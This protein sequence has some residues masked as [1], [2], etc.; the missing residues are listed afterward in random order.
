[1]NALFLILAGLL[2][3]IAFLIILPPLWRKHPV[4]VADL[5]QRN[6][7]IARQRLDE[8]K[9]Q[10]KAGALTQAQYNGQLA[11]LEQALSD[12]LDITS[13]VTVSQSQGRWVVYLIV[14]AVP[15]VTGSLYFTLGNYQAVSHSAEMAAGNSAAPGPEEIIKMVSGLA[16]RLKSQPDN[17][18]GWLMLGRSYKYLQQYPEAVEAFANAYR[19]LGDQAEVMLLYADALAY[20][21]N[22]NLAGKPAELVF[23]ALAL[24]PENVNGLWLGGMAKV[25]EGDIAAGIKMWRKLEALLPPESDARKETRSLIANIASQAPEVAADSEAQPAQQSQTVRID[26]QVSLAPALQKLA[27]PDHT[28]FIYAQAL[29]GPKM[30]LAIVR[31][32]VSDLPL[33]VSLDDSMAMMPAM[34][35]SNFAKVKLL[36]RI[37]KSGNAVSQPGDLIG[38][39]E[40]AALSDHTLNK[41]VINHEVK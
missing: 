1:M 41:I 27:R 18:Q 25:Q 7:I 39:V 11:E 16:E 32:K 14:L 9:D 20:A 28:V 37:S 34:K 29:S 12:D 36:A 4:E 21:N 38:V 35:L 23:K 13:H 33:T 3:L 40:Q 30:P 2:I 8:L 6:I 22:N 17:A 10:L 19:L 31:K 15:L 24:E 5:D 26:V